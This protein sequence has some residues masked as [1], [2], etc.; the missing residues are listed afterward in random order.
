M[1]AYLRYV[2]RPGIGGYLLIFLSFSLGLMAKPMLVTLPFVLLLLD[3]WPLGR[4]E[5]APLSLTTQPHT[6][7][8]TVSWSR[9]SLIVRLILEKVPLFGLATVSSIVTFLAQQ[10]GGA[11][12]SLGTIPVH[13]RIANALVAYVSYI[14]KTIWPHDLAVFYPHPHPG[15][16]LPVWQVAGAGLLLLSITVLVLRTVRRHP[17]LTIGWLWYLGTLVP[18]I[19]LVQ[20]GAHA[21]ADRYT[22]AP[23]IGLFI[24]MAWGLDDILTTWPHQR[25][26]IAS[27]T[28]LLLLSFMICSSFQIRHWKNSTTLFQ[29]TLNVTTNNWLAHNN[30]GLAVAV[31]G[32]T[33]GA[34]SHYRESLRINPNNAQAHNNLGI[35]LA[36]DE[37]PGE[38]RT[39]FEEA[40]RLKPDFGDAHYN[41]GILLL[42]NGKPEDAIFHY[43]KAVQIKSD[44]PQIHNNMANAL[45]RQGDFYAAIAHYREALRLEP[46]SAVTR[47]NLEVAL[48]MQKTPRRKRCP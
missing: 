4:F 12:E 2:K 27:A 31:E 19:G 9:R 8:S 14:E 39:H 13:I 41:L 36:K 3:Y 44:D 10:S 29:H 6:A 7:K 17:Y 23:L 32:D 20:V 21:M 35:A 18:V 45:L 46:N 11:V 1:E 38:A 40:L 24:I 26:A 22:Y 42:D 43:H 48:T 28:G 25:T 15:Q 37:K 34:L 16:S 33:A 5:F 30:M 47:R